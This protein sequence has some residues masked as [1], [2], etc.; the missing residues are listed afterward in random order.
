MVESS[1][2]KSRV[3]EII[4]ILSTFVQSASIGLVCSCYQTIFTN[5]NISVECWSVR[6]LWLQ[7][8]YA[9]DSKSSIK[10]S[11]TLLCGIIFC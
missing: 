8:L 2:N 5:I 11:I 9:N 3:L 6:F 10:K 4:P 7:Y 1:V